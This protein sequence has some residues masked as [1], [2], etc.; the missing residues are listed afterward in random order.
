[1]QT[2]Y[3]CIGDTLDASSV[4]V[5]HGHDLYPYIYG[6]ES[7]GNGGTIETQII[8]VF[9]PRDLVGYVVDAKPN[10]AEF[11][12]AKEYKCGRSK[13]L[14]TVGYL[15]SNLRNYV[16]HDKED[17]FAFAVLQSVFN[18][19]QSELTIELADEQLTMYHGG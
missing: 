16:E 19:V 13:C 3:L 5:I 12:R 1:M 7:R 14:G 6:G 9:S 10:L 15:P 4:S 2:V 17:E 18:A 8:V 11:A